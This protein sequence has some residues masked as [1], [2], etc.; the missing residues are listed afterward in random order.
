MP[1]STQEPVHDPAML[2]FDR[3]RLARVKKWMQRYSESGRWPGG[4]VLIARHGK[5]AYFD[6]AGYADLDS[7][8]PGGVTSSPVFGR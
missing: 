4:A 3:D 8:Y 7:R 1:Q 6:C 5:L 2:G